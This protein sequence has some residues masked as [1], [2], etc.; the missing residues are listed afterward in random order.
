M[1]LISC[2]VENYGAISQRAYQ[3]DGGITAFCEEN[4]AGKTTLASFIK[5]MFYG[6]DSYRSNTKEFCDR[7]H[8]YPFAGGNFGGNLTFEWEGHTYRIERFFGEK[9]ET[10]D[11][12]DVYCD[13]VRTE[14]FGEDVGREIFGIDKQSFERTLFIDSTEIEC[15]TTADIGARLNRF[16]EGIGEDVNYDSAKGILKKAAEMLKKT[17]G[18]GEIAKEKANVQALDEKI[19]NAERTQA[20]L[21]AKYEAYDAICAEIDALD[22]A[23]ERART[24][25]E[26]LAKWE[27]YE[28]ICAE[29]ETAKSKRGELLAGYGAGLPA[30]EEVR[31]CA[32]AIGAKREGELL[33][34]ASVLSE[35][36]A[37]EFSCLGLVF[38]A[39]VPSE[40]TLGDREQLSHKVVSLDAQIDALGKT[41][42]SERERSAMARFDG[43]VPSEDELAA[44][45][46]KEERYRAAHAAFEKAPATLG[47]VSGA[48]KKKG[49]GYY[50]P[51]AVAA[52]VIA[53]IGIALLFA[54]PLIGGIVT[55]L[56]GVSLLVDA[57]LYLN[58]RTGAAQLS[59]ERENPE[60]L[61]LAKILREAEDDVRAALAA[62]G[63][64][65][66]DRVE[67]A[68]Y[69][70]YED[71]AAC[72]SYARRDGERR[73]QLALLTEE[74]VM[75]AAA[76]D[77]FLAQ[78]ALSGEAYGTLL[79]RLRA[80]RTRYVALREKEKEITQRQA[81]L[82]KGQRALDAQITAFADT[83][84][85]AA[86]DT[87][88]TLADIAALRAL[89]RRVSE[90]E[91]RAEAYRTERGLAEKPAPVT[92]N[93][94]ES[95]ARLASLRDEKSKRWRD[96]EQDEGDVEDLEV[97]RSEREQARERMAALEARY[98]VL[99]AAMTMLDEADH[100]LKERYVS[101]VKDRFTQYSDLIERAIGERA[102]MSG[103]FEITF[104]VNG[105][106]RSEKHLSAGQRSICALCFRLALVEN[107]YGGEIPFLVMDDPFLAMDETHLARVREVMQQLAKKTQI[108]YFTCHESRNM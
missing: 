6:L 69:R 7:Q 106:Q 35:Q 71:A 72:A 13:G 31:A 8:F 24:E 78:Y 38:A 42:P 47:T 5:A 37:A 3:F 11:S 14:R 22:G 105:K 100:A 48:E 82:A 26:L 19:R 43:T 9:S 101:P 45:K 80:D 63:D 87:E 108:L 97:Y 21:A 23:V 68:C 18:S 83:Y 95:V 50:L 46:E 57:F 20:G 77:A 88:Q 53:V 29:V 25:N 32:K 86:L 64:V 51:V 75:L 30:E 4:G 44:I 27:Q 49:A 96:I 85:E 89:D 99:S 73:A 56:G 34:S 90:G 58:G 28:Y 62:H 79:A 94:E 39:G 36:E 67:I 10:A 98:R 93:V 41:E 76:L 12:L 59:V 103:N 61:R 84:G 81:E 2:Y 16:L 54:V 40:E 33:A 60:R 66:Q 70:L 102:M 74:R 52:A 107:M 91:K 1:K 65:A 92:L 15:A 104:D 17:R 55:A